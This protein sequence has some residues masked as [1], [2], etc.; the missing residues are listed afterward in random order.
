MRIKN[1]KWWLY[2]NTITRDAVSNR[3]SDWIAA[4]NWYMYLLCQ[5]WQINF[6]WFIFISIPLLNVLTQYACN[7]LLETPVWTEEE[8]C[9]SHG[10]WI[11][12]FMKLFVSQGLPGQPLCITDPLSLTEWLL[13]YLL[14]WSGS[15]DTSALGFILFFLGN[16]FLLQ[17]A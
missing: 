5:E 11:K 7:T 4:L 13:F 2:K 3:L 14:P 1:F 6:F 9:I 10:C 8:F 16:P 12:A 15:K 17:I